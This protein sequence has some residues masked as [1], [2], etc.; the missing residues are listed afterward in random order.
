MRTTKCSKIQSIRCTDNEVHKYSVLLIMAIYGNHDRKL[1][2]NKTTP[3]QGII[4]E[5]GTIP[6]QDNT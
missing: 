5:Q 6:E 3:E 2:L 4:P 1:Y